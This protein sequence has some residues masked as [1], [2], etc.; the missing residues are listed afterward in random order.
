MTEETK[1]ETPSAVVPPVAE[2]TEKP[3]PP[4]Y[5][6][7][8]W[9]ALGLTPEQK[10]AVDTR[11]RY[12]YH[13]VKAGKEEREGLRKHNDDLQKA[14]DERLARLETDKTEDTKAK[15]TQAI[16]NARDEGRVEDELK[17]VS[18]LTSLDKPLAK[19]EAKPVEWW[20]AGAEKWAVETNENGELKRPWIIPDSPDNPKATGLLFKIKERWEQEGR[21]LNESTLPFLLMELDNHMQKPNG[22][23]RTPAVLSTSQMKGPAQKDELTAEE[24]FHADRML[25]HRKDPADRYKAYAAQK[26]LMRT[27]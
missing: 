22:A 14:I 16:K 2:P 6:P 19:P 25:A 12:L 20:K 13:Q 18:Q 3:R 26:A 11:T 15:I 23:A 8:D 10:T 9:D 7:V 1:T 4:G 21:S 27:K 17:L 5:E 24:K